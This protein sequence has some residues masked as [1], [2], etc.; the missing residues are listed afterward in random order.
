MMIIAISGKTVSGTATISKAVAKRLKLRYF[1]AGT[2]YKRHS[3][4]RKEVEQALELLKSKKGVSKKF[5]EHID[6]LH[7]KEAKRGNIVNCGKLAIFMLKDIADV[8]IWI[9]C[10]FNERTRR[11]AKRDGISLKE[12]RRKLKE[13]ENREREMWKKIYGLDYFKQKDLA[14]IVVNST[15]LTEKETVNKILNS[16]KVREKHY[17][18]LGWH[19]G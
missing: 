8:K 16:I 3:K 7:R 11:M 12:A 19:E 5:H 6:D 14:D 1:D 10:A 2:F 15:K 13:K 4:R 17:Q 18:Y 9:E